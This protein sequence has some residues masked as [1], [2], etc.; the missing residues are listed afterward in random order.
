IPNN[1]VVA[2]LAVRKP[3]RIGS[4]RDSEDVAGASAPGATT[5]NWSSDT[6]DK[7]DPPIEP[8]AEKP[9]EKGP[10][11][12]EIAV[13][14]KIRIPRKNDLDDELAA[15]LGLRDA[16][17][18]RLLLGEPG[19]QVPELAVDT[20]LHASVV[21]VHR[22]LVFFVLPGQ[23]EGVCSIRQFE[24]PPAPDTRIEVVVTGYSPQ[25]GLYELGIPGA[26][27]A[28][29]D[30]SDLA[31]GVIVDAK[32]T[33]LNT[34]GLECE[35]NHIRG[36][37]P[38]SQVSLYRM[39]NLAEFVGQNLRCVVT[40]ANEMRKKFVLS[41]RAVLERERAEKR[42]ALLGQLEV[43]ST[44]EGV[45]TKIKEFGAFV[46][47]GGIEG[48]VH[49]SQLSWERIRHPSEVLEVGQRIQTR[50]E[51]IDP[52][53]G[54]ISLSYRELLEHPW[55]NADSQ[56]PIGAIVTGTVTRLMEFGAFVRVGPGMEGLVHISELSHQRVG[57]VAQ[58]VAEGQEVQVKILSLDK[59]S[60]R[61]SL[62]MKAA[63]A[64]AASEAAA[65]EDADS[66]DAI[67]QNMPRIPDGALKGG[68][69]RKSGGEAFGLK[70]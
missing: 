55:G 57:R 66:D 49:I 61:M 16:D 8:S 28:V 19:S 21:K 62:S 56:F 25:D 35:V 30:W 60:Q 43:G 54:K 58:V 12:S 39:E 68:V 50:V 46:D 31:E 10:K 63:Q 27:V 48:L 70:W 4:Q 51:K 1:P 36:F 7:V 5:S 59:E 45:V 69:T 26:S 44:Q 41:H 13:P 40:E 23:R 14:Q 42:T 6:Q 47:I 3:I 24:E 38:A 17:M 11:L 32:I 52:Q 64:A 18:S 53:T 20:R 65:A 34:G 22:D 29:A 9:R 37:I 2:E 67:L 33:A 15:E